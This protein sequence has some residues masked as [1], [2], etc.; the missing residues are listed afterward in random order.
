MEKGKKKILVTGGAGFVG[1]H[2]CRELQKRGDKVLSLDNYFTGTKKNH[3]NGIEYREGHTA[4]IEAL[5]PEDVALVYHLGEYSRVAKS[6]N[7]PALVWDLNIK[8][9]TAVLEF[10]RNRNCKLVYAGSSTKFSEDRKDGVKGENLSPYTWSKAVNSELV[11]N[12][13]KWYGLKYAIVYFYNVYGPGEM[14]G[15]Y[16][17]VIEIFKQKYLDGKPL[18]MR[19]P[20]TQCRNYTHVYD[21]VRGIIL[22]GEKGE[23]DKYGIGSDTS[24]STRETAELFETAIEELPARESSRPGAKVE[25]EKI[26]KLGWREQYSLKEYIQEFLKNCAKK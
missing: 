21:T 15:E 10:C 13:G 9:S 3:I 8:G 1:S 6:I 16:G 26:K 14:S 18:P 4:D 17:T 2:L 25:N 24:Y 5:I 19:L 22:A 20:G 7:E 11:K 12:Y 23:G